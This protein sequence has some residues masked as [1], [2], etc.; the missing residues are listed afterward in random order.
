MKNQDNQNIKRGRG[1][2]LV[3]SNEE[4]KDAKQGL[5]L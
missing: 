1:R 2:P 4:R 5:V 3:Y